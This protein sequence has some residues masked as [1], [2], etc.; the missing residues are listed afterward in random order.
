M[1]RKQLK[2]ISKIKPSSRGT[3]DALEQTRQALANA[4]RPQVSKPAI[5]YTMPWR[6][7][8]NNNFRKFSVAV[9]LVLAVIIGTNHFGSPVE[10]RTLAFSEVLKNFQQIN[11]AHLKLNKDGRIQDVY[12]KRP[13]FIRIECPSEHTTQ[14][15]TGP[16]EWEIIT[17]KNRVIKKPSTF[18]QFAQEKNCDVIDIFFNLMHG[19]NFSG[20]FAETPVDQIEQDGRVFD[21]YQSDLTPGENTKI[22]FYALVDVETHIPY[23]T[24]LHKS[25][26]R[27]DELKEVFFE[28]TVLEINQPVNDKLFA[29]T[30]P[31]YME[32]IV[33]GPNP[34]HRQPRLENPDLD[35]GS[36]FTGRITWAENDKPVGE[37]RLTIIGPHTKAPKDSFMARV[38]TDRDGY[39]KATGIPT[40]ITEI[41]VRSW[42]LEWPAVPVFEENIGSL[43]LAKIKVDTPI[44]LTN[45]DFKVY[46]PENLYANITIKLIDE[47]ENP[48]KGASAT[49][50]SKG[51]YH[52]QINGGKDGLF[53]ATDIWPVN[54]PVKIHFRHQDYH[55]SPYVMRKAT[56]DYFEIQ[57]QS[58]HNF[59]FTIPLKREF[60]LKVTDPAG[61]AVP[62]LLVEMW[63]G[64]NKIIMGDNPLFTDNNGEAV[65]YGVINQE[66]LTLTI[67]QLSPYQPENSQKPIASAAIPILTPAESEPVVITATFDLR[68]ITVTA[69]ADFPAPTRWGMFIRVTGNPG[70]FAMFLRSS[71][72]PD[73]N[74]LTLNGAPA[75][76][77]AIVCYF[78]DR[79]N[80]LQFRE[81]PHTTTPGSSYHVNVSEDGI[82]LV[83]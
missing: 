13:D 82:T 22:E 12:L 27:S 37:A 66:Q 9:V 49:L 68:P 51:L 23:Q 83:K 75:G 32:L 70:D 34:D 77:I 73:Q 8:M 57:P 69:T 43:K 44:E 39:W 65:I 26:Q 40:G 63:D 33:K 18:H 47:N 6:L 31:G 5:S 7:I 30:P 4:N 16:T 53:T 58:Q 67:K 78:R 74:Q 25:E 17:K 35:N 48:V 28:L 3:T 29:F 54:V 45:L 81:L 36:T 56:T 15:A 2:A 19:D 64:N 71:A 20:F 50:T 10:T 14:I 72:E 61:N 38:E 21:V 11:T 76:E 42:E 55:K 62:G 80:T 60:T 46:K 59:E 52:Q 41:R 1:I 24:K 79:N